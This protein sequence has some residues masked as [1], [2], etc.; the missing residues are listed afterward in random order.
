M[1]HDIVFKSISIA[2]FI[3]SNI[4]I[5]IIIHKSQPMETYITTII[6]LGY[7]R[8]HELNFA[9]FLFVNAN[10]TVLKLGK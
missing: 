4:I 1:H 9:H 8:I 10:I 7:L 3:K 2:E 5:I 6:R